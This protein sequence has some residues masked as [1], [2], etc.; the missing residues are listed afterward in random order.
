[1]HRKQSNFKY[2]FYVLDD[3]NKLSNIDMKV[4]KN[5]SRKE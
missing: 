1:M 5:I 4:M 2:D 3:V